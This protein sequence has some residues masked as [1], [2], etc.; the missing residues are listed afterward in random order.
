MSGDILK[1]PFGPDVAMPRIDHV[2]VDE[3]VQMQRYLAEIALEDLRLLPDPS[4]RRVRPGSLLDQ[5]QKT[6]AAEHAAEA[7][8]APTHGPADE[9][10]TAA[11]VGT[12]AIVMRPAVSDFE[13][14][15][16]SVPASGVKPG[17]T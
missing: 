8:G 15:R 9:I 14:P 13:P 10:D 17:E 11:T 3:Q 12:G 5:Y 6:A 2:M 16:A 1:D 7:A 4:A